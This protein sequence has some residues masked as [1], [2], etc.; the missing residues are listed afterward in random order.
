MRHRLNDDVAA[1]KVLDGE[2]I[3]INVV[4]GRYYSLEGTGTLAWA[5]LAGGATAAEA[6]EALAA[7]YG[8]A[9]TAAA[10]DVEALAARLVAESLLAPR[11]EDEAAATA[12]LPEVEEAPYAAPTMM[13]FTDMEDLLA[14]DPPLPP[15]DGE[16]W[17]ASVHRG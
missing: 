4:T 12:D 1:A 13:A 10:D 16:L 11:D 14:F 9:A 15:T 3:V 17:E 7:R 8:V 2:T 6:G 5:L